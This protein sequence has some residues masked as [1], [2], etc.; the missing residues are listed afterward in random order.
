MGMDRG[1]WG[2]GSTDYD[3]A[4]QARNSGPDSHNDD[5]RNRLLL[6]LLMMTMTLPNNAEQKVKNEMPQ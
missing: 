1:S 4:K 3:I 2:L 6:R 5:D